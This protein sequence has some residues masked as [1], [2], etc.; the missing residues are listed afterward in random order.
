MR[1][2]ARIILVGLC[3]GCSQ[4]MTK[5]ASRNPD[6]FEKKRDP[7]LNEDGTFGLASPDLYVRQ[8]KIVIEPSAP[9]NETGS[10]ANPEDDRL[11]LFTDS[12][13][14][15]VGQYIPVKVVASKKIPAASASDKQQSES[16]GTGN[17]EGSVKTDALEEELLKSLPNLV[18]ANK[19]EVSLLK[20]FKMKIIHR[21]PNGDVLA[22]LTRKS[23]NRDEQEEIV[24]DAKIPADRLSSGEEITTEDLVDVKLLAQQGGESVARES[25]TWEDDYSLRLS[26]FTEAKSKASIELEEKR[27]ELTDARAKLEQRMK[28]FANEK[29]QFVSQRDELSKSSSQGSESAKGKTNLTAEPNQTGQAPAANQASKAT[30]TE[31]TKSPASTAQ[32]KEGNSG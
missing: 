19:G 8:P 26:G 14:N 7:L 12:R 11:H 22:R 28:S 4:Q 32:G 17:K 15:K 9:E 23:T 20:Q 30:P 31:S 3:V 25:T 24:A 29:R 1:L 10:L 6:L 2:F 5:I 16:A 27:R 21:Y 13:P 18:P